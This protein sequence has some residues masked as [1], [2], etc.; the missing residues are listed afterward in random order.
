MFETIYEYTSYLEV[1]TF[2]FNSKNEHEII[3][4]TLSTVLNIIYI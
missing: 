4:Q 2:M 3:T 1:K